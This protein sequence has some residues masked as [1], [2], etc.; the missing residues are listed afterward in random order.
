MGWKGGTTTGCCHRVELLYKIIFVYKSQLGGLTF[1]VAAFMK[2]E[3][4]CYILCLERKA[5]LE[6]GMK[7]NIM[8]I[9]AVL[10]V[11]LGVVMQ[12]EAAGQQALLQRGITTSL[13]TTKDKLK[14]EGG[15]PEMLASISTLV[16]E[17]ARDYLLYQSHAAHTTIWQSSNLFCS[18]PLVPVLAAVC[19]TLESFPEAF[20][21]IQR[22]QS[23]TRMPTSLTSRTKLLNKALVQEACKLQG[24]S[25]GLLVEA[26]GICVPQE[27]FAGKKICNMFYP[28]R[29]F[30]S[31]LQEVEDL[32]LF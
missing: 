2:S 4:L 28:V 12:A 11:L 19:H 15:N 25:V 6:M 10:V 8:A 18:K 20:C 32:T 27:W 9:A 26:L 29:N 7:S 30:H 13:Q 5:W 22:L 3:R 23:P 17:Q 14:H 24:F 21:L 31:F 1:L 16:P